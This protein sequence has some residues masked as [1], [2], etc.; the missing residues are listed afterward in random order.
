MT[1]K[2]FTV[3]LV[4]FPDEAIVSNE[5]QFYIANILTQHNMKNITNTSLA[6]K[7][8]DSLQNI[9]K[10]S[11]CRIKA[12]FF[13]NRSNDYSLHEREREKYRK[14]MTEYKEI[15]L[16]EH[17][18]AKQKLKLSKSEQIDYRTMNDKKIL[19]A[20]VSFEDS[21]TAEKFRKMLLKV[22]FK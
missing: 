10:V 2:E 14:K 9:I 13:L 16:K 11:E 12:Q 6:F 20:Y 19:K 18:I 15:A 17:F 4:G 1:V 8:N 7:F 3:E 22:K 5:V 21:E